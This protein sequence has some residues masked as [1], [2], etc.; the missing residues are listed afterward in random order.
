MRVNRR[1]MA[2]AEAVPA[3]MAVANLIGS[4]HRSV[5]RSC[6]LAAGELGA[7]A[8]SV[9][10]GEGDEVFGLAEPVGD[11]GEDS[12][13]RVRRLDRRRA[14]RS[15]ARQREVDCERAATGRLH[16]RSG[17]RRAPARCREGPEGG[18]RSRRG[19]RPS[20]TLLRHDRTPGWRRR[21][22]A[23][24]RRR[25]EARRRSRQALPL[26]RESWPSVSSGQHGSG[27]TS[28][29]TSARYAGVERSATRR[30]FAVRVTRLASRQ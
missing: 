1:R 17:S 8:A 11:A 29:S 25:D 5:C 2:S 16:A 9:E 15:G 13:F 19:C 6:R 7:V 21:R 24:T 30:G 18:C 22:R 14:R 26:V 10:E 3:R 12:Q 20:S 27:S 28:G 4:P 23:E